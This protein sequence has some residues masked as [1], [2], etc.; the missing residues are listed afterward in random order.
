VWRDSLTAHHVGS[1]SQWPTEWDGPEL[2]WPSFA[3]HRWTP[4]RQAGAVLVCLHESGGSEFRRLPTVEDARRIDAARQGRRCSPNCQGRHTIAWAAPGELHL[5]ASIWDKPPVPASRAA[6]LLSAGY[7]A[8]VGTTP[9]STPERWP[10]PSILNQP[11]QPRRT[12]VMPMDPD[13]LDEMDVNLDLTP[14]RWSEV[15]KP[16]E[17]SRAP[18]VPEEPAAGNC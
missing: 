2:R 9:D 14:K 7:E 17:V 8:P 6:A 18:G 16:G 5:E 10:R 4:D 15:S 1:D 11:L 3:A 13:R 12:P